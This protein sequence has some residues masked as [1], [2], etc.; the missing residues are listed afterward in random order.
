[1]NNFDRLNLHRTVA[2]ASSA[3]KGFF[4]GIG[5]T[6]SDVEDSRSRRSQMGDW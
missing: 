3:V 2:Y 5:K 6:G 1:M 4:K